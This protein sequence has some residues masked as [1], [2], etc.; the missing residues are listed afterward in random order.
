MRTVIY[1]FKYFFPFN[2]FKYLKE[3]QSKYYIPAKQTTFVKY[4]IVISFLI[5]WTKLSNRKVPLY[6]K[7]IL[8]IHTPNP[9]LWCFQMIHLFKLKGYIFL[10]KS[11]FISH[12]LYYEVSLMV[13]ISHKSN[14]QYIVLQYLLTS[15]PS[16]RVKDERGVPVYR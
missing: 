6:L 2:K 13:I 11:Q 9:P 3:L 10:K 15:I 7:I 12:L 5:F 4:S 8:P 1:N 16:K 14:L